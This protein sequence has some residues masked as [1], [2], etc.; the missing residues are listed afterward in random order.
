MTPT[1]SDWERTVWNLVTSSAA[2][3]FR[4]GTLATGRRDMLPGVIVMQLS[5]RHVTVT[6]A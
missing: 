1:S 5:Q 2:V 3:D 6:V 4:F